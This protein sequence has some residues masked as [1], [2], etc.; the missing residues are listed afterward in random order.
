LKP[1]RVMEKDKILENYLNRA[2]LEKKGIFTAD[3][4]RLALLEG[5]P[6]R[7]IQPPLRAF[8]FA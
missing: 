3:E 1:E 2:L 5:L 6:S 8:R 4:V 7:W